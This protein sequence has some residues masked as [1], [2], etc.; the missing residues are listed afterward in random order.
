MVA[1]SLRS[2]YSVWHIARSLRS[3]YSIWLI[4]G[5]FD[6]KVSEANEPSAIERVKRASY[7]P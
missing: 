2:L 4:V 3:L 5:T 1:R 6:H 7:Q